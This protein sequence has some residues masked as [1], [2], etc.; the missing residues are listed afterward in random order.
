MC[1][2]QLN[3]PGVQQSVYK[4]L[5]EDSNFTKF[6]EGF[7]VSSLKAPVVMRCCLL[8][9]VCSLSS[10]ISCLPEQASLQDK[11][12]HYAAKHTPF[13]ACPLCSGF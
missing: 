11:T 4:A 3:N 5:E 1:D 7:Q 10:A 13:R 12:Q 9:K 2:L 6:M 8:G